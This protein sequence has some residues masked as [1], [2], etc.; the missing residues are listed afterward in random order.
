MILRWPRKRRGEGREGEIRRWLEGGERRE[1]GRRKERMKLQTD[2]NE[3]FR[4]GFC[5]VFPFN[6][7]SC[8]EERLE[9]V[10][11]GFTYCLNEPYFKEKV[12]RREERRGEK[13]RKEEKRREKKRKKKRREKKRKEEKRREKKRKEEKRREKKR[14]EE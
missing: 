2:K 9:G 10:P 5:V 13:K 12:K 14:K 6:H 1:E 4:E 7:P 3:S 8:Y 11:N